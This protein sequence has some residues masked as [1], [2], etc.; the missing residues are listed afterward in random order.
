MSVLKCS[1][2]SSKYLTG[3]EYNI[4]FVSLY[5]SVLNK[6]RKDLIYMKK[7]LIKYELTLC[8]RT[9]SCGVLRDIKK[10]KTRNFMDCS[11]DTNNGINYIILCYVFL[12]VCR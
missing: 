6:Y 5:K 8:I 12:R 10:L 7:S 3:C 4:I 11:Y 9:V 1:W 2:L